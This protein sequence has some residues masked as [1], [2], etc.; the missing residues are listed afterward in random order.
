MFDISVSVVWL[1]SFFF[2]FMFY[3]DKE[4]TDAEE[5]NHGASSPLMSRNNVLPEQLFCL[6]KKKNQTNSCLHPNRH[7]NLLFVVSTA[8]HLP[9]HTPSENGYG[10]VL[11]QNSSASCCKGRIDSFNWVQSS[12][13]AHDQKIRPTKFRIPTCD[14]LITVFIEHVP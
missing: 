6:L 12:F 5:S 1:S 10:Y 2:F 3:A 11:P 14:S 13:L 7:V 8:F 9:H 4:E